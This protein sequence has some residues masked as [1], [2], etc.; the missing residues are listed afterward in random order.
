MTATDDLG[1]TVSKSFKITVVSFKP[2]KIIYEPVAAYN[3][4]N[5][6]EEQLIPLTAKIMSISQTGLMTVEYN[7]DVVPIQNISLV[8]NE[9]LFLTL[10]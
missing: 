7:K 9:E 1:Q 6:T 4:I 8:T 5:K 10:T 2:P 3:I